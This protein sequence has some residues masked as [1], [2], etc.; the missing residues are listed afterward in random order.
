MNNKLT[1]IL[2]QKALEVSQLMRM[3]DEDTSHPIARLMRGEEVNQPPASF[4]NALKGENISV[5]AEIKRQSPSKGTLVPFLDPVTLA[6]QYYSG[7]ASALSILTDKT[8]FGGEL[9][10]LKQVAKVNALP[11]LRKDFIIDKA[12]I[13]EAA[14]AGASAVLCI[15]AV[16]GTKLERFITFAHNLNLDV[17][18]EVHTKEE[19]DIAL[20]SGADIIGINN[21]NLLT[22]E[23]NP[24][25]ALELAK[26]IPI[27][28]I[29]VAE[30]GLKTPQLVKQYARAGFDAVL[31][32][33]ALVT[34]THPEQFIEDCHG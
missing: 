20:D 14:V 23:V 8:F 25:Y 24:L 30:S 10:D 15:V 1:P 31:I 11:I 18:V 27:G 6:Q 22:L 13:A 17:L 9:E 16:L 4:K 29:K 5:I 19:L 28:I 2:T 21:R 33:E 26:D 34:S 32:G 12:Q 3:L 7:G